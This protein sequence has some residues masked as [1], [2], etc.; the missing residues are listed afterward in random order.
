MGYS[1]FARGQRAISLA[2]HSHV[3]AS[4]PVTLGTPMTTELREASINNNIHS[5]LQPAPAC[6]TSKS[7][8]FRPAITQ[9]TYTVSW[10][11][12]Y[13]DT[14]A[15]HITCHDTVLLIGNS[16]LQ[17]QLTDAGGA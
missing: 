5:L 9:C 10:S 11:L 6:T 4:P 7:K 15:L 17:I 12:P 3:F 14:H 1:W 2:Y 13:R 16:E 8:W